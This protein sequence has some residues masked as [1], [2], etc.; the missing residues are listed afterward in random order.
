M[1]YDHKKE[2]SMKTQVLRLIGCLILILLVQ[3][4]DVQSAI[5]NSEHKMIEK[6]FPT[7]QRHS[8]GQELS[9]SSPGDLDTSFGTNGIVTL[10]FNNGWDEY[11]Y[12]VAIQADNKIILSGR[13]FDVGSGVARLNADGTL[14][15]SFDG[16]GKATSTLGYAQTGILQAD[17][18]ILVA[19]S[20]NTNI[21][22]DPGIIIVRYNRD[23]GLDSSFG[24]NGYITT[25]ITGGYVYDIAVDE[26]TGKIIVVGE[27]L[28]NGI[29]TGILI[30]RYHT[31]G[32]LD[33][34]F[35]DNGIVYTNIGGEQD[36]G[37]AVTVNELD[38][39]IIV[40]GHTD[41]EIYYP[42]L[43]RYNNDGS[44][45]STFGDNG[46]AIITSDWGTWNAVEI[47]PDNK[48]V[49]A[50]TD[51]D[52][53]VARYNSD[54]SLDL[55]F[56][57]KGITSTPLSI[58]NDIGEDLKIQNDGKIIV[59]GRQF[60][61]GSSRFALLR[62][63]TNGTLDETFNGDGIVTTDISPYRDEAFSLDIQPDGKIVVIGGAWLNDEFDIAVVRYHGDFIGLGRIAGH[64]YEPGP[65]VPFACSDVKVSVDSLNQVFSDKE[66]Y[67]N[68]ELAPGSYDL[69][70]EKSGY[71]SV[72]KSNISVIANQNTDLTVY[73]IASDCWSTDAACVNEFT[74]I[75]PLNWQSEATGFLNSLC[76]IGHR[77]D[78][79]DIV[80]AAN[81]LFINIIDIIDVPA[82]GDA[83][84]IIEGFVNCME[85]AIYKWTEV[86]LGTDAAKTFSKSVA[87]TN[88]PGIL[89]I[90]TDTFLDNNV[91]AYSNL[92][93]NSP[94]L[95][96]YS[97]DQ[98]LGWINGDIEHTIPESYIYNLGDRYQLAVIK[99]ANST[100]DIQMLG[101]ADG[102]FNLTILS[103]NS[104]GTSTLNEYNNLISSNGSIT[105]ITINQNSTDYALRIDTDGDSNVDDIVS[106]IYT[107]IIYPNQVYIPLAYKTKSTIQPPPKITPTQT[108]TITPTQPQQ[109]TSTPTPTPTPPSLPTGSWQ[110]VGSGSAS[111]EGVSSTD[112][113][114]EH[115]SLAIAPD[116]KAY[117]VWQ[118]RNST[119]TVFSIYAKRWNGSAW[120]EVGVGSASGTGISTG[121]ESSWVPDIAISSSGVP[122]VAWHSTDSGNSEIY[123]RKWNGSS[124][125]EVG[126]GS[127]SGG[128]IS[129]NGSSSRFASVAISPDGTPYVAYMDDNDGGDEIYVKRWNGTNWVEVG[130]GSASGGGISQNN[131][132][133][134]FPA[135][136]ISPSG[137]PYIT[138]QD[139]SNG[140]T[141]IY[142]RKWNVSSWVEVGAG[143]ASG[144]GISNNSGASDHPSIAT[145]PDGN[146]FITW[147]DH[148][149]G[150]ADIYVR[151]WNGSSWVEVGVNSASAG[152][153]SNNAGNSYRP[154]IDIGSNNIPHITWYDYSGGA[155]AE[156][157]VHR[158]NGSSWE[159]AGTGSASGGGIS[160]NEQTSRSPCIAIEPNDTPFVAWFDG[161]EEIAEIYVKRWIE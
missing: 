116:G 108:P 69:L 7:V 109:P 88:P 17:G 58:E 91:L 43:I 4:G 92:L 57:D 40:A 62:Y 106:P 23:G 160:D 145:A 74:H 28:I 105:S 132:E 2:G 125:V 133:S 9:T 158:W 51:G 65:I 64:T 48:I 10:G 97:D 55:G 3:P 34:S 161:F 30:I 147:E 67:F 79:D 141:E 61:S 122:Y 24:N 99:N 81:L 140:D 111:G 100:Y 52:L 137:T 16:D 27:Y 113:G 96:I 18:K 54:G 85:N 25:N 142:V 70:F 59:A 6:V 36:R 11:G 89:I 39:K 86:N 154:T 71:I 44:L 121:L 63:E 149:S 38:G 107:E 95:H 151:R 5:D 115:P 72:P 56:G 19:G 46:W 76:E 131:G 15:P 31:D 110:E 128:G 21:I 112:G 118:E 144:G 150:N 136:T 93:G 14:D 134:W 78:N 139:D 26:S 87:L 126:A 41:I 159:E 84:D 102:V 50:G 83:I 13:I 66:G 146:P 60:D 120:E 1:K 130:S 82:L 75:I 35:G 33:N 117:V 157:Y 22:Q 32:S 20:T 68:I 77:L 49:V 124:W 104:D 42:A 94:E 37:Y 101:S 119:E 152:G 153:I 90:I 155:D 12:S 29:D 98:H 129:N 80:G 135:M 143:S 103:P 127:A 8:T 123:I 53:S 73:M 47:Q 156:I 114:S 148:S 45:D 138:W